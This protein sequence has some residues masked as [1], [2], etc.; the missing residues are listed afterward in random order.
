MLFFVII[1]DF[2]KKNSKHSN[3]IITSWENTYLRSLFNLFQSIQFRI[4]TY[5][6]SECSMFILQFWA[7][8]N[9]PNIKYFNQPKTGSLLNIEGSVWISKCICYVTIV[10]PNEMLMNAFLR[11]S[12]TKKLYTIG[13]IVCTLYLDRNR[14]NF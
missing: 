1:R 8:V 3:Q 13:Y 5:K 7:F 9:I 12:N 14:Q 11:L 2:E 6:V 10:Y 4:G